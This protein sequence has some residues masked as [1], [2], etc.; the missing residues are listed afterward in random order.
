MDPHQ[1]RGGRKNKI[2]LQYKKADDWSHP[3]RSCLVQSKAE[4]AL[5]N[6]SGPLSPPRETTDLST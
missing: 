3:S 2:Q 4:K 5:R 6:A 1:T